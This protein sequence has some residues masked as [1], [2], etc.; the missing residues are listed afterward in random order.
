MASET[1][2]D[3]AAQLKDRSLVREAALINGEW[4]SGVAS[5]GVHIGGGF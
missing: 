2:T 1:S 4:R 3:V 5:I